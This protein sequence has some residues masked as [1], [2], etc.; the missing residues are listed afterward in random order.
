MTKLL[1]QQFQL[2]HGLIRQ[3]LNSSLN[4]VHFLLIQCTHTTQGYQRISEQVNNFRHNNRVDN[5][6]RFLCWSRPRLQDYSESRNPLFWSRLPITTG[7]GASKNRE[8]QPKEPFQHF[9]N[10]RGKKKILRHNLNK[11]FS[12]LSNYNNCFEILYTSPVE[13]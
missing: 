13:K 10:L 11:F 3:C 4:F 6:S 7:L 12:L 8:I 1:L 9:I 2:T 5:K